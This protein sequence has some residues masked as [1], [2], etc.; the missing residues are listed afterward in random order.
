MKKTEFQI[1]IDALKKRTELCSF[2]LNEI[3]TTD[4]LNRL[5]IV[6]ATDL[7]NFCIAEEEVM[8]KI[9]MVDLYHIIGMG[10]LTPPQMM[11]FTYAIQEYLHYRPTI[12]AIAKGLDSIFNLPK[13]PVA[14]QY[15]LMGLGDLILTSGVGELVVDEA[16]VE[17]YDKLKHSDTRSDTPLL[18]FK[19]E[20]KQITVD[21]AQFDFF[22]TLLTNLFKS[23][24]SAEN[25]RNKMMTGKEYLGIEWIN[26]NGYEAIGH[27]KSADIFAKISSYYYKR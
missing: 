2:H 14:T 17:D 24:L 23:P 1:I 12:K 21:L 11:K 27:I 18:P 13:I 16:S 4:D 9:A 20:G 5:T 8:T 6:E 10:E 22:V 25:F 26:Y 15:R 7:K 3:S 19:L